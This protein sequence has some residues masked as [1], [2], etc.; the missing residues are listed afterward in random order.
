MTED[1]GDG[2]DTRGHLTAPST[3]TGGMDGLEIEAVLVTVAGAWSSRD[4]SQGAACSLLPR[5]QPV[6]LDGKIRPASTF[7][8]FPTISWSTSDAS[9]HPLIR[10]AQNLKLL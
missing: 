9:S 8:T 3:W 6:L 2:R 1:V 4:A 10:F 7:L 5:P